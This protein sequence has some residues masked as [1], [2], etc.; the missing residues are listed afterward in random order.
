MKHAKTL[1]RTLV[2]V[3]ATAGGLALVP[4]V[5]Q[6]AGSLAVTTC[7]AGV[8]HAY[9]ES[10]FG[11]QFNCPY[12][13]APDP[14]GNTELP[15]MTLSNTIGSTSPVPGGHL[16]H[17]QANAPS[18]FLITGAN[19]PANQMYAFNINNGH[20]WPGGFYWAGGTGGSKIFP[21]TK[22]FS[23]SGLS[24]GFFGFTIYCGEPAGATCSPLSF[25]PQITVQQ[26][27]LFATETSGPALGAT[28][29]WAHSGWVRGTWPLGVS[30]NSPSGLCA[31]AVSLAAKPLPGS[32]S[33]RNGSVWHQC[34]APAVNDS[35]ATAAYG[36]GG[37]R[38]VLTARDA[39]G[40]P[41]SYEKTVFVDNSTPRVAI[42]G[43][44]DAP[45]S[46]GT[47]IVT[48]TASGSQSG[49]DGLACSVD[50][51]AAHWYPG[52]TADV[53]VAGVAQHTVS[54]RA[55]NNAVDTVGA[56][57]WSATAAW[58]VAIRVPTGITAAFGRRRCTITRVVR[59]HGKHRHRTRVRRCRLRIV[60]KPAERI[61]FKHR[62]IISGRLTAGSAPLGGQTVSIM[63]AP[64]NGTNQF[65]QVATA[66]TGPKGNWAAKIPTGP[67]R[68]VQAV[69]SGSSTYEPAGSEGM[70]LTVPARLVIHVRPKRV[71][72]A[73]R[74]V[75]TGRLRGGFIP[76]DKKQAAQLLKIRIGVV[77][78]KGVH[79]SVG[80]PDI[81]PNGKFHTSFCLATGRGSV[82]YWFSA[83]TLFETNY[84][85][86]KGSHSNRA[87][88]R[89]GP[90]E[91]RKKSRCG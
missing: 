51:A 18:G 73:S 15:G 34:A 20:H 66:V 62:A 68:I 81:T 24:T 88:V 1:M 36:Q 7:G 80:V 38:L 58:H 41:V 2:T 32:S 27:T 56:H 79:A 86:A 54:C 26:I 77:G 78:I 89:V 84:P 4:A 64:L 72:W 49:I 3:C 55:A 57:G 46:A 33:G 12:T 74:L 17:W 47:Q 69:Y 10:G 40:V 43:P 45:S 90:G 16:A 83:Q 11:T 59:G 9:V 82:R 71:P 44:A 30:G 23:V 52:A 21:T 35:V 14:N 6:A 87:I 70:K 19:V 75:I 5:A 39:A 85:Y 48:A 91:K 53:P 37:V 63:T 42:S 76:T 50:G 67:S 8:F 31:I 61:G 29:L 25:P 13:N 65:T 28:G 60:K 22:S